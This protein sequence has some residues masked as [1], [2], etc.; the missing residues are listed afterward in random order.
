MTTMTISTFKKEPVIIDEDRIFYHRN[1]GFRHTWLA[2]EVVEDTVKVYW[3]NYS[4]TLTG[5]DAFNF[6][7]IVRDKHVQ[8]FRR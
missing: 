7:S 5:S 2:W 4:V 1:G 6:L 8:Q 3:E